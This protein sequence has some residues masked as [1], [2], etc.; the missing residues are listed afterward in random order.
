MAD[1]EAGGGSCD[2]EETELAGLVWVRGGVK[3]DGASAPL[4]AEVFDEEEGIAG[5]TC[6]C[7]R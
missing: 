1:G 6:A 7:R 3:P 2:R 5:L 4:A